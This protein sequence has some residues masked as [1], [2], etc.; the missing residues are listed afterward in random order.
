MKE[1]WGVAELARQL[2]QK[3][4]SATEAL[5]FFLGRI[6]QGQPQVNAFITVDEE[7]AHASAKKA[8][9]L[10][11]K[12]EG[13]PLCG[14]PIAHKDLFCAKGWKTTCG[15][16]MLENFISPYDA[17][18]VEKLAAAGAVVVGKTNMDEFAMGSSNESSYF[19]PVN[20]PWDLARVPGGSSGG[21]A[22][23]V[24]ARLVPGATG[25][26][27]GGSIRQPA[28]LCGISGIKPT[29]GKVSRWGMVAFASSLDQAGPMAESA[30]DL[31]LL[32]NAMSGF[33]SRDSTSVSRPAEDHTRFFD[34]PLDGLRVGVVRECLEGIDE[35]VARAFDEAMRT[36]EK[37]G[38]RLVDVHLP[39]LFAVIP[40]YYTL[41]PAEASSNLARF[42]GV[43]YGFR[44][45]GVQSLEELYEKSRQQGFGDE[46][47]RRILVG[48][49][50]LSAG[51]YDQYYQKAQKVRALIA[52]DF[53]AAFASC[54]VIASPTS[55][56]AAFRLGEKAQDPI[57][58]YLCDINTI[59]A[60]L[61]GLP[62]L[63]VPMGF[64]QGL[65][66]GLQLMGHHFEE[67]RLLAL[68]HRYQQAT[69]WHKTLPPLAEA[70]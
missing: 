37:E 27:T 21:S 67:A 26:D 35:G 34:A 39:R 63:S 18:I 5:D 15:S 65:P 16:K 42:D 23:A 56:I 43:R 31:A 30:L 13:G 55:P 7:K 57:S 1:G 40:V 45:Q 70:L 50:V 24:A 36:L 49:F 28:A 6:R 46:V 12:G 2:R 60:N 8:Q 58:M 59:P 48:T 33:D 38:A 3:E 44:A 9:A 32:L 53:D 69:S 52:Q 11:D 14:V 68:A 29:Y 10:L 17:A 20:N 4:L 51:Y 54:D 64:A 47:K 41:A 61:A 19:G 66:A 25:S 22:A 62:A